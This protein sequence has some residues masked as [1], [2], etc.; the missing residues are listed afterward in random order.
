M[1]QRLPLISLILNGV[2]AIAVIVLYVL[3][4]NGKKS[5]DLNVADADSTAKEIPV[6]FDNLPNLGSNGAIA[7]ID[8][9]KFEEQ[10]QFFIDAKNSLVKERNKSSDLLAKRETELRNN[11]QNYEQMA[12][13]YSPEVRQKR[14]ADLARERDEFM[15]YQERL[16]EDFAIKQD[17]LQKEFMKK[18]DTY[19]KTLNKEKNYSYIFAY[20]KGTPAFIVYAKDSLDITNQVI[21][22]LNEQYK[23]KK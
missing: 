6:K 19:L 17:N 11:F 9:D 15:A 13:S 23:K 16:E 21:H 5:A 3:H 8:N 22:S 20:S 4:F 2:L 12:P 18:L 14:E 10:Y 7:F 1:N